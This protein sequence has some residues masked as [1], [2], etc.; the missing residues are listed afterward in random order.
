MSYG[1]I[2]IS[3][4]TNNLVLKGRCKVLRESQAKLTAGEIVEREMRWTGGT[5]VQR[6]IFRVNFIVVYGA[7]QKRHRRGHHG[8]P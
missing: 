1:D 5:A 2:D 8:A 7:T 6:V 3:P 4:L